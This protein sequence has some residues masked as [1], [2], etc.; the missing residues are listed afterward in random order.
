MKNDDENNTNI[1]E[2]RKESYYS[3][4]PIISDNSSD[5][6][7]DFVNR[8]LFK[9]QKWKNEHSK[10]KLSCISEKIDAPILPVRNI[11]KFRIFKGFKNFQKSIEHN[12]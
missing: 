10:R 11:P 5:D 2:I 9:S 4:K 12:N 6:S 7:F 3:E 1:D 8:S